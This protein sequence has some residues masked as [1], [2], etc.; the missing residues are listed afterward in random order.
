MPNLENYTAV[1]RF[2]DNNIGRVPGEGS[3]IPTLKLKLVNNSSNPI[4]PT[5]FSQ[6]VLHENYIIG[7]EI[8]DLLTVNPTEEKTFDLMYAIYQGGDNSI[9]T[10]AATSGLSYPDATFSVTAVTD[11]VN[12]TLIK[13]E[14]G[15]NPG[16]YF[17]VLIPVDTT[18]SSSATITMSDAE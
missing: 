5:M 2:S 13:D 7:N 3:D 10:L 12:C 18:A 6:F 11:L 17:Y 9:N 4:G 15:E 1:A 8:Y 14:D 16:R